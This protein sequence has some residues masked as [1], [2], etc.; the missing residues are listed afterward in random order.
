LHNS[1][2]KT[3]AMKLSPADAAEQ[4]RDRVAGESALLSS[5][6]SPYIIKAEEIYEWTNRIFVFLDF[7]DE[8]ELTHVI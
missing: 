1:S 7:M 3:Y 4:E 5:I 2:N 8:G 6:N